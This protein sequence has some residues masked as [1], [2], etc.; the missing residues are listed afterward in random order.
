MISS[1]QRAVR[2]GASHGRNDAAIIRCMNYCDEPIQQPFVSP[3]KTSLSGRRFVI[4]HQNPRSRQ[5]KLDLLGR[6]AFTP[7]DFQSISNKVQSVLRRELRQDKKTERF[8]RTETL[9]NRSPP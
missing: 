5:L 8:R 2:P 9:E 7:A 3:H 1:C 4:F 6:Q